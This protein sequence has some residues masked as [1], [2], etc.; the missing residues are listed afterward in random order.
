MNDKISSYNEVPYPSFV[1]PQ[2]SPDRLA[3]LGRLRGIETAN[4]NDSRSLEL[5]CG[6]GANLI[7]FAYAYPESRFV[8][9]DL[10]ERHIEKAK[11]SAQKLG[12][13]NIEFIAAD[14]CELELAAL[15]K[16]DTIVAHGLFSWVPDAV[17]ERI[18]LI[19]KE[20]L[21]PNGVGYISYNAFPGCR[22][23]QMMNDM[24][25]FHCGDIDEPAERIDEAKTF[26][27]FLADAV[28]ENSI[29]AQIVVHEQSGITSRSDANFFHDDLSQFNQPFYLH[30]FVS[31][32][33][34]NGLSYIGEAN[35]STANPDR[36]RPD[37]RE[38]IIGTSDDPLIR[39]QYIDFVEMRRFRSSLVC[40]AD[41]A[42]L[43]E[44]DAR[45]LH[46]MRIVSTLSADGPMN[47]SPN[48]VMHFSG[49]NGGLDVSHPLTKAFLIELERQGLSGA[50]CEAAIENTAMLLG[51]EPDTDDLNILD[52]Y[53]SMMFRA[54]FIT[55]HSCEPKFAETISERPF[56]SAFARYQIESGS[57][58]VTTLAEANLDIENPI[59]GAVIRLCDGLHTA[60]EI[61]QELKEM[62]NVPEDEMENLA[63]ALPAMIGDILNEFTASGLLTA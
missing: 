23:R 59:V 10:A 11:L 19:Y 41:A 55:A 17:R 51:S 28:P 12:L 3:T 46:F 6:D 29:Q 52:T 26:V 4:P 24:M 53:L 61:A 15:G 34:A 5:G 39:E 22:V 58:F 44:Y 7:A 32:L 16:F 20:L 30:E 21:E 1:F 60:D 38:S 36:L 45:A 57:N 9:I 54:E 48:D 2:T 14:I 31:L 27:D 62:V 63:A 40:H 25:R 33:A 50:N 56:V 49:K 37:V 13:K 35:P 8:G 18:L 47:L 43:A 42:P